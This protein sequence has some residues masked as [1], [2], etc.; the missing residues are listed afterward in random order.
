MN[1]RFIWRDMMSNKIIG[2]ILIGFGIGM[3]LSAIGGMG[4]HWPLQK[5]LFVSGIQILIAAIP[6]IF[7]IKVLKNYNKIKKD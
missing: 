7:G 4:N 2:I 5:I 1:L 6:I 3:L